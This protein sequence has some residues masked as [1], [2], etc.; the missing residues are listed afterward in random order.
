MIVFSIDDG[1]NRNGYMTQIVN[2]NPGVK[3]SF[4]INGDN[5]ASHVP[6]SSE[7]NSAISNAISKGHEVFQTEAYQL[8]PE[9]WISS[10]VV[11]QRKVPELFE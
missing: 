4:F 7:F 11:N 5:G 3:F 8:D 10:L 9:P 2:A 6:G 1:V